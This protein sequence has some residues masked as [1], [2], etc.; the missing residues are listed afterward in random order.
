MS[1]LMLQTAL[2]CDLIALYV[3][4]FDEIS[5]FCIWK[6][7]LRFPIQYEACLQSVFKTKYAEERCNLTNLKR[8]Q[9][10]NIHDVWLHVRGKLC[11]HAESGW[12]FYFGG[13]F[14]SCLRAICGQ[15]D[16]LHLPEG[17]GLI[18]HTL[19]YLYIILFRDAGGAL[20]REQEGERK[21]KEV[22]QRMCNISARQGCWCAATWESV[23]VHRIQSLTQD[24]Q[25]S[26]ISKR[27]LQSEVLLRVSDWVRQGRSKSNS[28][29]YWVKQPGVRKQMEP[30]LDCDWF[31]L[32]HIFYIWKG[33]TLSRLCF[34]WQ[35][36][37]SRAFWKRA[38][39]WHEDGSDVT[40]LKLLKIK[41]FVACQQK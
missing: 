39:L 40:K 3:C 13:N 27:L 33:Q 18:W 20:W 26:W 23:E 29:V 25:H 19:L 17:R 5:V 15:I 8:I 16:M 7:H 10:V 6:M 1:C 30:L 34:I 14:C 9:A 11:L 35:G 12:A 38:T 22:R 24:C 32:S 4:A 37:G 2:Q 41:R 21:E 31:G 36:K 28:D